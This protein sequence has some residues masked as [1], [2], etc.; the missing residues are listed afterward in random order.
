MA[1][2][3]PGVGTVKLFTRRRLGRSAWRE[4][5][6][7]QSVVEALK[8]ALEAVS[9]LAQS[10]R[11]IKLELRVHHVRKDQDAEPAAPASD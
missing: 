7:P 5:P 11:E 3:A 8:P 2:T 10:G 1:E 4:D 6:L 9:Y